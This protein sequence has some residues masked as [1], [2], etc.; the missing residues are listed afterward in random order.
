V[1]DPSTETGRALLENVIKQQ[2]A[3]IA[4]ANDFKLLMA[5]GQTLGYRT[6]SFKAPTVYLI[7]PMF[8]RR[9]APFSLAAA[10]IA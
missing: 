3:I 9:A 5:I 6:G 8:P 2:A 4:Y 10:A 7:L 1:L